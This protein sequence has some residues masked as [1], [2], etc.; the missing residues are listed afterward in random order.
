MAFWM[1]MYSIML[2]TER[3]E[4]GQKLFSHFHSLTLCVFHIPKCS[5]TR[6]VIIYALVSYK[7]LSGVYRKWF[8]PS[9]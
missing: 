2:E 4:G 8:L 3:Q 7:L 6:K 5:I 9:E 1:Y